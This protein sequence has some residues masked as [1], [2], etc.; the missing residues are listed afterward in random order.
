MKH[1]R[2]GTRVAAARHQP[3]FLREAITLFAIIAVVMVV[4]LDVLS[5][6]TTHRTLTKQTRE[7]ARE[8]VATWVGSSNDAQAEQAAAAYLTEHG[9]TMVDFGGSHADGETYYTV[10]ATRS[11]KT[12]VFRYLARLPW[13]GDW[14]DRQLHPEVRNDSR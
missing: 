12:Y 2:G 14:I 11:A 10:A 6:Y 1:E 4:V 8:A 13:V 5:V 9:S 7:A 3:A